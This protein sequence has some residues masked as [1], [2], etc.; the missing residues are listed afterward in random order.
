MGELIPLTFTSYDSFG[1]TWST[2][3]G[4]DSCASWVSCLGV[5]SETETAT[6]VIHDMVRSSHRL[7]F[8][9]IFVY[10][11]HVYNCLWFDMMCF[12]LGTKK[13]TPKSPTNWQ[14]EESHSGQKQ[15]ISAW[16]CKNCMG[17]RGICM[18]LYF[19]PDPFLLGWYF[20]ECSVKSFGY[21]PHQTRDEFIWLLECAGPSHRKRVTTICLPQ[22]NFTY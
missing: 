15:N 4:A 18:V 3:L 19:F 12:P 2:S 1:D 22:L 17:M 6:F 11:V 8:P 5:A 21:W 13:K 16:K 9:I 10:H 14:E 7:V 20:L